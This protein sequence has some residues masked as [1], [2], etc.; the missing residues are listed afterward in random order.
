MRPP[1]TTRGSSPR[2]TNGRK[3]TWRGRNWPSRKTGARE[4]VIVS[5]AMN[6]RGSVVI[7]AANRWRR[8]RP[9]QQ[10]VAARAV[11]G[12]DDQLGAQ[13]E[14]AI[15]LALEQIGGHL[16]EQG[17]LGQESDQIGHVGVDRL[18]VGDPG[19]RALQIATRP[20]RRAAI[21]PDTPS[22]D[23][24]RRQTGSRNQSSMRR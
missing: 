11:H 13:H 17:L 4:S 3:S 24:E 5:W 10:V 18:A 1:G 6:L 7:R 16:V 19:A 22:R 15:V 20:A 9:D 2:T 23:S 8:V 12:L 14:R 21:I